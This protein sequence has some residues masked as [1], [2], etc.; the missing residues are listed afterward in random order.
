MWV[1]ALIGTE[2]EG[3]VYLFAACDRAYF[4]EQLVTTTDPE[5]RDRFTDLPIGSRLK[6]CAISAELTLANELE[7]VAAAPEPKNCVRQAVA[8]SSRTNDRPCKPTAA[9]EHTRLIRPSWRL[10]LPGIFGT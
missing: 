8:Q 4:Y 9:R 1:A 3:I 7:I 10:R 5:Y 2:A 6:H